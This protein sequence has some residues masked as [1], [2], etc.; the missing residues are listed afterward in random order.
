M[1]CPS[2]G[3]RAAIHCWLVSPVSSSASAS[4]SM[5]IAVPRT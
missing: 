5:F 2:I 4:V 3:R 1:I